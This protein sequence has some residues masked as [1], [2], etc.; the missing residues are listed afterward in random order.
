MSRLSLRIMQP[1]PD[2]SSFRTLL[3]HGVRS[4]ISNVIAGRN[5]PYG[6]LAANTTKPRRFTP[7]DAAFIRSIAN[8]IAQAAQRLAAQKILRQSEEYYRSIIHSCS[9]AVTVVNHDGSVTFV[10]DAGCLMLGYERQDLA[11]MRGTTT[12]H[13]DDVKAVHKGIGATFALGAAT[14]ECRL[15]RQDGTW[16]DCEVR[17]RRIFNPY[18]RPVG[19][20]TTRD[21][22]ERKAA[23][24]DGPQDSGPIAFASRAATRGRG[25]RPACAAR[26]RI[27]PATERGL[28]HSSESLGCRIRGSGA[29]AARRPSAGGQRGL[30]IGNRRRD[31][32]QAKFT[33]RYTPCLRTNRL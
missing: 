20:F 17:G 3:S 24:R 10:N 32:R 31:R 29:T 1:K 13:P 6:V 15:R 14:Y 11:S 23:E 4:G 2:S 9:D 16:L 28:G 26:H 19:V 25:F 12:V 33:I 22:S 5:R 8:L 7:D 27:G 18:R 21:I 30:R